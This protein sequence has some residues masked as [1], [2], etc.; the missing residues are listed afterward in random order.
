MAWRN[1][2]THIPLALTPPFLRAFSGHRAYLAHY[3][4]KARSAGESI[5]PEVTFNQ[6]YTGVHLN[7][8]WCPHSLRSILRVFYVG[9]LWSPEAEAMLPKKVTYLLLPHLLAS[10]PCLCHFH[11][12][13]QSFLSHFPNKLVKSYSQNLIFGKPNSKPNYVYMC[14]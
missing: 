13:Y 3:V 12:L 2:S 8:L 5:P 7:A 1:E 10:I 11:L 14:T 6:W 4:E 9:S